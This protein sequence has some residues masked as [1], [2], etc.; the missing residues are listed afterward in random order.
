MTKED[1]KEDKEESEEET[2]EE[3]SD[4]NEE[5]W[6][7]DFS[8]MFGSSNFSTSSRPNIVLDTDEKPVDNLEEFVSQ[9]QTPEKKPEETSE[10]KVYDTTAQVYNM[11]DYSGG[12]FQ[13]YVEKEQQQ[14]RASLF[15]QENEAFDTRKFQVPQQV[16]GV[17]R[18]NY[19][20]ESRIRQY[21][22]EEKT[23]WK[24]RRLPHHRK[25]KLN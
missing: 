1:N 11:P 2:E 21:I 22:E 13:K 9:I 4:E 7:L 24:E 8:G 18:S 10:N 6:N 5:N 17:E 16:A 20:N 23:P 15:R 12:D 3:E 19:P 25:I 14:S